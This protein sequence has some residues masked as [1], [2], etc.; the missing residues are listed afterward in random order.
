VPEADIRIQALEA[1]IDEALLVQAAR[2]EGFFLDDA[3]VEERL[4]KLANDVGGAEALLKW[5]TDNGYSTDSFR[6]A[7]AQAM[8]AAWMRDKIAV[9]VPETAE[10]VHVQQILLPNSVQANQIM[11]EIRFGTSFATLA[12]RQDPVN[13]GDLGWIPRGYLAEAAIEAAAFSLSAGEISEIIETSLGFHIL[14]VIEVNANQPLAPDARLVLQKRAIQDWLQQQRDSVTD[15]S[16]I[17]LVIL[18]YICYLLC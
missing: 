4:S 8:A 16:A 10:Q 1:L 13:A 11:V 18:G 9:S 3:S 5:M 12:V 15:K 17:T 2:K 7:L 6:S 14:Q